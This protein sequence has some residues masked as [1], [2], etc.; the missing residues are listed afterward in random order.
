MDVADIT[1][2]WKQS[3]CIH[4][5]FMQ[6]S[7]NN[8]QVFRLFAGSRKRSGTVRAETGNYAGSQHHYRTVRAGQETGSQGRADQ[9]GSKTGGGGVRESGRGAE[10]WLGLR[11]LLRTLERIPGRTVSLSPGGFLRTTPVL[12]AGIRPRYR[13]FKDLRRVSS[14]GINTS[15]RRAFQLI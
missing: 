4:P 6:D 8:P 12:N 5:P 7:V 2:Y 14:L 9:P 10:S 13:V 11:A 3:L 1:S 15:F